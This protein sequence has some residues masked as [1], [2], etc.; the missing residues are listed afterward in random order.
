[1]LDGALSFRKTT[2]APA[3]ESLTTWAREVCVA[4]AS[5]G[6]CRSRP[7]QRAALCQPPSAK[8]C[9]AQLPRTHAAEAGRPGCAA[10]RA[11]RLAATPGAVG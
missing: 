9:K 11:A 4:H 3:S 7:R 8:R 2:S 10:P 5:R 1:V 6:S